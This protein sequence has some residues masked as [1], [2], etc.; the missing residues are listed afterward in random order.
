MTETV[1]ARADWLPLLFVLLFCAWL[2][3]V[4]ALFLQAAFS[5]PFMGVPS[6]AD[7]AT[8]DTLTT[9]ATV[10]AVGLPL[11]G[12]AAA[13]FARRKVAAI[14]FAVALLPSVVILGYDWAKSVHDRPA[15]RDDHSVC[16]EHSGGG[17]VCP[18][19]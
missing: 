18:G 1:K 17:N 14:V 16:Q 10:A 4:P 8:R 13:G 6:D 2:F 7:L 9:W 11:A 15:P 12:L 3:G 5:V 19:D